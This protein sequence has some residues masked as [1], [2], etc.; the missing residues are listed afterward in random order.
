MK[1]HSASLLNAISLIVLSLWGYLTSDTPSVT[2][3]IPSIVGIIL[4]LCF[5]GVKNENKVIAHIAVLLT[6]VILFALIKPLIGAFD[7]ADNLAII[8]VFIM[9][10][11]T[12]FA[13]LKFV[14]SFIQARKNREK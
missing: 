5:T 4:L 9:I 8:R 7:R 3:L 14:Q 2:A 10:L 11:T 6:L 13:M 12:A 1:A